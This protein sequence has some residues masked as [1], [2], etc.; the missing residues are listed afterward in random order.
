MVGWW[1]YLGYDSFVPSMLPGL[2]KARQAELVEFLV[3]LVFSRKGGNKLID[4]NTKRTKITDFKKQVQ[5]IWRFLVTLLI[6]RYVFFFRWWGP[7]KR[8]QF[9]IT[10]CFSKPSSSSSCQRCFGHP[11]SSH[12][13]W[14]YVS[15]VAFVWTG[16]IFLAVSLLES[17]RSSCRDAKT[18]SWGWFCT[19]SYRY[20]VNNGVCRWGYITAKCLE[21]LQIVKHRKAQSS[22]VAGDPDFQRAYGR[23]IVLGQ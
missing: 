14:I 20:W 21:F 13:Y 23:F 6:S 8:R 10:W 9:A 12:W 2:E 17:F 4:I 11:M 16:W 3:F 15:H 22:C 7:A 19:T 1:L 5:D 18:A